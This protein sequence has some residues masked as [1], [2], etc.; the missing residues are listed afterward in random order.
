MAQFNVGVTY[1]NGWGVIADYLVAYMWY[2][3]SVA[4]GHKIGA[5]NREKLAKLT[6]SE[7]ISKAQ[8]MDKVCIYSNY[9]KCGY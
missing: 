3:V 2:D 7:D 8:A 9:E 6:T 5:G 4:N 1:K